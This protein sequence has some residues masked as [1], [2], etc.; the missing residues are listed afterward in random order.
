MEQPIR[1][2]HVFSVLNRGGA[3]SRTMD[4][5]RAIDKSKVQ[6]DFVVSKKG[7]LFEKE[8]HDLGGRVYE[9]PIPKFYRIWQYSKLWDDF[10]QKHPEYNI[11]HGHITSIASL[12]MKVAKK[13]NIEKRILHIRSAGDKGIIKKIIIKIININIKKYISHMF[14]VSKKA[15]EYYFGKKTVDSNKVVIIKNAIDCKKNIYDEK[16]RENM[17]NALGVSNSFVVGHVGRYH[18]AKN[19]TFILDVFSEVVKLQSDS[20]L[21]LVGV[22]NGIKELENKI[23][24]LHLQENVFFA[25][26]QSN[27][28]DYL[29]AM[30]VFLFPSIY[31]GLPGAVLEAQAAGLRCFISDTITDEVCITDLVNVVSLKKNA[32]EWAEQL[33]KNQSYVRRN[34][35][36]EL[37]E[38][39]F[40]VDSVSEQLANFYIRDF[41]GRTKN[42]VKKMVLQ[43]ENYK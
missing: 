39:G 29:Q 28:S 38:A 32:R 22:D 21:L 33:I 18:L 14:A 15:G 1:V 31:E 13:H 24:K 9:I 36:H 3:E 6:F 42:K 11:I 10:L 40:N 8:I 5:Y 23:R 26:V 19:H 17:R 34:T 27:V 41:Y 20:V 37:D 30:D 43:V 16:K 25:G 2:L 7:G 35:F 12:Y 4:L